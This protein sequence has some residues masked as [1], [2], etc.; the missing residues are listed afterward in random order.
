ML[1]HAVCHCLLALLAEMKSILEARRAWR[2]MVATVTTPT[3]VSVVRTRLVQ[4]PVWT[5]RD[6]SLLLVEALEDR[7]SSSP[8]RRCLR[9]EDLP[10]LSPRGPSSVET[11]GA[12]RAEDSSHERTGTKTR[13]R[14]G[15]IISEAGTS[16]RTWLAPQVTWNKTQ[17]YV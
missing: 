14:M 9:H 16:R 5:R 11:G 17:S 13:T 7:T 8:G 10:G 4:V 2:W 6:M 3:Q 12:G 15:I 1:L